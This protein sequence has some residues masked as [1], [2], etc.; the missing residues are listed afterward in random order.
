MGATIDIRGISCPINF[1][2]AKLA[3]DSFEAG[4]KV[5]IM[6]DDGEPVRSVARSLMAEGHILLEI[7]DSSGYCLLYLEK[8]AE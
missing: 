2:K 8:G 1:V 5:E 4:D 7:R 6:V 3:L